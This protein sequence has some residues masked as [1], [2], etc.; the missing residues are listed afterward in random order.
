MLVDDRGTVSIF[1]AIS[2]TAILAVLGL[3]NDGAEIRNERRKL[4]DVVAQAAR[5]AAQEIDIEEIRNTGQLKI[6][7]VKARNRATSIVERHLGLDSGIYIEV[8]VS[9]DEVSVSARKTVE[10][11]GNRSVDVAAQRKAKATTF[12]FSDEIFP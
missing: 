9:Q 8:N 3:L 11:W 1:V 12:S 2:F 4:S 6:H 5:G 7:K 10:L